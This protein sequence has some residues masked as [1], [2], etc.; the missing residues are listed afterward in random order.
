[1]IRS[2]TETVIIPIAG[3]IITFVLCYEL[4]IMIT[5]K[6]NLHDGVSFSFFKY[7][8]KMWVAV[9]LVTHTFDIHIFI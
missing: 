8:L 5:E 1:M 7:F 2:L 9:F 6:N 4:I 3:I